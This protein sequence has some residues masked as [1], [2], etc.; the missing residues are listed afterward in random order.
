MSPASRRA[1]PMSCVAITILTPDG[2]D[3]AHDV[4]HRLGGGGIEARGRLVEKQDFRIA[5]ERAREREPL[6]LAAGKFSRRA[7]GERA[8]GRPASA[9]RSTRASSRAGSA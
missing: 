6:L 2:R 1:C 5:R 3:G 8:R 4:L 9:V 7:I